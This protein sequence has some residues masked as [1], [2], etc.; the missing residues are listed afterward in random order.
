[1][2]EK[3]WLS[4]LAFGAAALSKETTLIFW[5]AYMLFVLLQ[6]QWRWFMAL[7]LAPLPFFLY[8]LFLWQWLGAFGVGSGGAGATSFSLMPLGGW[9]SIASVS[10]AA[11]W[12]ISLVVVPMSVLPSLAGIWVSVRRLRLT[13][14]DP[15]TLSLFLNSLIL[16]FLPESTFREPIAMLRLNMGLVATLLIFGAL[17]RSKRMLT[18][19]LLWLVTNILLI[20]GVSGQ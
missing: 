9:F 7:G 10:W 3:K 8:Q 16:L 13:K 18:Y 1:M 14:V 2:K 12:L 6:R 4:I 15:I 17:S 11:F 5:A 20:K 19:N